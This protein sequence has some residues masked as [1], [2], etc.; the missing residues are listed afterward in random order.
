M[1]IYIAHRRRKTSNAF[2]FNYIS[3]HDLTVSD[4][5][6]DVLFTTV[7]NC[8]SCERCTVVG[9]VDLLLLLHLFP[10]RCFMTFSGLIQL[11]GKTGGAVQVSSSNGVVVSADVESAKTFHLT[12][13]LAWDIV[14]EVLRPSCFSMMDANRTDWYVIHYSTY[15]RVHPEY[16]TGH[17][18]YFK[19]EAS[20]I[21]HPDTF[22]PGHYA[23]ESQN[24]SEWYFKSHSDGR[25]AVVPR[26]NVVDYYDTASFRMYDY[27]TSCTYS[28]LP[29]PGY[30][31]RAGTVWARRMWVGLWF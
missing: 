27:N 26:D 13:C 8:K 9:I 7:V 2:S 5:P 11:Y 23:L 25:L 28:L 1:S 14:S 30:S 17:L 31:W 4:F 6:N 3:L 21:L 24:L 15:L 18:P 10:Y 20:F 19:Q 16:D 12:R 29:D 22:Y